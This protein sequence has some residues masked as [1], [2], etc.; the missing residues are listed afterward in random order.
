MKLIC[1]QETQNRV[2]IY[3]PYFGHFQVSTGWWRGQLERF[4]ADGWTV[5]G[6][7]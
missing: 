1:Y 3:D 5:I 2:G 7:L 6:E 4:L